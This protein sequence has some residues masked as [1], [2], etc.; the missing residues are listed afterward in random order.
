[1]YIHTVF[2]ND[3]VLCFNDSIIASLKVN[4]NIIIMMMR[5][6]LLLLF[7]LNGGER[8]MQICLALNDIHKK[9]INYITKIPI[10]FLLYFENVSFGLL[11]MFSIM[12]D[13]Y[14]FQHFAYTHDMSLCMSINLEKKT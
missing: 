9:Y 6:S 13:I 4:F 8:K 10:T 12:A 5:F 7:L 1:M 11:F 2:C 14:E 3:T